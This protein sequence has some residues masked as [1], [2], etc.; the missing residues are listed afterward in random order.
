MQVTYRIHRST[1][2]GATVFALSR[3]LDIDLAARLEA[4]LASEADGRIV[5]DLQDVTLVD[6]TAVRFLAA[7]EAAGTVI[8][9]CP[10]Y[11]RIWITAESDS[12]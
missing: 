2:P 6:R 3:V 12:Q 10:E 4:L 8:V 1:Q 5:L 9:N 7:V 11:V